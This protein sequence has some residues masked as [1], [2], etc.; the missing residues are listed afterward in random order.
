MRVT[1]V[2][3]SLVYFI[4]VVANFLLSSLSFSA[5]NINCTIASQHPFAQSL[6]QICD[7]FRFTG[8]LLESYREDFRFTGMLLL[9]ARR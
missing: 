2:T 7:S 4:T 6:C 8:T 3:N 1:S 5:Q 9:A